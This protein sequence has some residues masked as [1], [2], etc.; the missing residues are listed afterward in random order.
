ME[1]HFKEHRDRDF[2]NVCEKMRKESGAYLSVSGIARQAVFHEAQSFYLS[3]KEY[4]RI[5]HKAR[6]Y[7]RPASCKRDVK[8]EMYREIRSRFLET[9]CENPRLSHSRIAEV[10]SGQTAPRFYMTEE[11]AV[12]L[13]YRLLKELK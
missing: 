4:V 11:S 12:G 13:Y 9:K 7:P 3:K 2:F 6:V 10:I 1:L 8:N 5:F